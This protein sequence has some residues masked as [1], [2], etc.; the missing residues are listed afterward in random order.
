MAKIYLTKTLY[1]PKITTKTRKKPNKQM[2]KQRTPKVD[3]DKMTRENRATTYPVTFLDGAWQT[4]VALPDRKKTQ[5]QQ[6]CL[7]RA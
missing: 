6:G 7:Y 5:F 1:L 3:K 2:S 4:R